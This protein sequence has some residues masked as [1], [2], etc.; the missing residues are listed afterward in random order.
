MRKIT[1]EK[2][3]KWRGENKEKRQENEE[4]KEL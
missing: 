3:K 4:D 1:K 2:D